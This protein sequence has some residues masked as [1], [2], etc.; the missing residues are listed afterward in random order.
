MSS[1]CLVHVLG[2]IF[3]LC[4]LG[5]QAVPPPLPKGLPNRVFSILDL[6]GQDPDII[7][8]GNITY[9]HSLPEPDKLSFYIEDGVK[10]Y[11]YSEGIKPP[12]GFW[13]ERGAA[14]DT[15][16]ENSDR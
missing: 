4:A 12:S 14:E 6:V 2:F 13:E 11:N 5:A 10:F 1:S 15:Q 9:Q 7:E 8:F 3:A 16:T